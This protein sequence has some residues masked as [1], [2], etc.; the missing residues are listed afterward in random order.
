MDGTSSFVVFPERQDACTLR[1]GK[2]VFVA[3][4]ST[5]LRVS[6][7]F[8]EASIP[9][10][11]EDEGWFLPSIV[12]F[13]KSMAYG[14][15]D[16]PVGVS[17]MGSGVPF[18]SLLRSG[19]H[20]APSR[21]VSSRCDCH[22]N[23]SMPTGT[24]PLPGRAKNILSMFLVVRNLWISPFHVEDDLLL[25]EEASIAWKARISREGIVERDLGR[26]MRARLR[27]EIP[28]FLPDARRSFSFS[29]SFRVGRPDGIHSSRPL[30]LSLSVE[31]KDYRDNPLRNPSEGGG[32]MVSMVRKNGSRMLDRDLFPSWAWKDSMEG[33]RRIGFVDCGCE[34]DSSYR[35]EKKTVCRAD[36]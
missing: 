12:S 1:V 26:G 9:F 8:Y 25:N 17:T 10:D 31:T 6:S 23:A 35:V 30:S 3:L 16:V 20:I 24:P 33:R 5:D 27:I 29:L 36:A 14:N 18:R 21:R 19:C 15:G 11:V 2:D 32:G 4:R 34:V 22:A 13:T 28:S 7:S